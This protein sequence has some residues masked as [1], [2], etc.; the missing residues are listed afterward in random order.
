VSSRNIED[1]LVSSS[2]RLLEDDNDMPMTSTVGMML[3]YGLP[4]L[5]RSNS[6]V[7]KELGNHI[8]TEIPN[9]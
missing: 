8:V 4:V 2:V 5:N 3:G 6:E 7:R 1:E 9:L